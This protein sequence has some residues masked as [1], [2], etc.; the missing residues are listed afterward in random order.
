MLAQNSLMTKMENQYIMLY[1]CK[2]C[3]LCLY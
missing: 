2:A 1:R 3:K